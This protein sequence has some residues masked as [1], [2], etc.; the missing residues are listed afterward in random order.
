MNDMKKIS[1][2]FLNN[3]EFILL[4]AV[5][6]ICGLY[7]I[8]VSVGYYALD[9]QIIIILTFSLLLSIAFFLAIRGYRMS[10]QINA[11][12][13]NIEKVA[14]AKT[15]EILFEREACFCKLNS[16]IKQDSKIDAT[17]FTPERPPL[18]EDQDSC[19]K[20]YWKRVNQYLK[21]SKDFRFRRI[22]TIESTEKFNW[23]E[24]TK[25]ENCPRY[26][27]AA[28]STEQPFPYVN[29]IIIDGKYT[30]IFPP[31]AEVPDHSWYVFIDD[32]TI[33]EYFRRDVFD[34]LWEKA[35][36][37]TDWYRYLR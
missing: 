20:A 3:I 14:K 4:L 25:V 22:V 16:L 2:L 5:S 17:Y 32:E 34:K 27:L 21:K 30:L 15:T 31:H 13:E 1:E 18:E 7:S 24:S 12:S 35:E 19:E 36:K 10:T 8:L 28:L 23:V 26:F 9:K 11:I 29:L 6:T 33:A 37:I